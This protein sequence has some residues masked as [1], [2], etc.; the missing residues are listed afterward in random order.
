VS[1]RPFVLSREF[2]AGMAVGLAAVATL[3]L[4]V[5]GFVG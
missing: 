1:R 5:A 4:T 3:V 2:F